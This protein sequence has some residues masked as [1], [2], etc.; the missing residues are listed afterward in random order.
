MQ[1]IG[2]F[3]IVSI[4]R[5]DL[6]IHVMAALAKQNVCQSSCKSVLPALT[7]VQRISLTFKG[8]A[9]SPLPLDK[10]IYNADLSRRTRIF[11]ILTSSI[12]S[13]PLVDK[14]DSTFQT[15]QIFLNFRFKINLLK[16][17][18]LK[19]PKFGE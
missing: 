4:G 15:K 2:Q 13:K 14:P 16:P 10:I 12:A 3:C 11:L 17:N 9:Q 7:S 8:K 18:K 6:W 5:A 1:K 19:L